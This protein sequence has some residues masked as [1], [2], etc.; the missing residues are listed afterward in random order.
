MP[1]FLFL[2]AA[3]LHTF[4]HQAAAVVCVVDGEMG[5]IAELVAIPAE[6]AGTEGVK[7]ARR[8]LAALIAEHGGQAVLQL[9]RSLVCKGNG[10]NTPG[11]TG[12]FAAQA[13]HGFIDGNMSLGAVAQMPDVLFG[14][15]VGQRL[16]TVAAAVFDQVGD[17]VDQNSGFAASRSR[18]NQQRAVG[19]ID[20]IPLTVVHAGKIP[21]DNGAPQRSKI[22]D[23]VVHGGSSLIK[24]SL[25][26]QKNSILH[27]VRFCN[28]KRRK[29]ISSLPKRGDQSLRGQRNRRE[30]RKALLWV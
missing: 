27:F 22:G 5:G 9:T 17:T 28:R 24:S 26:S 2:D 30:R 18:Q 19:V 15:T 16:G 1:Q 4:L 11:G 14:D 21:V 20:S 25:S 6:N 3:Q 10:E 7:R 12:V 8:D 23:I 13:Q 29:K